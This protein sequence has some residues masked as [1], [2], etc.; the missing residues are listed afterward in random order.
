MILRLLSWLLSCRHQHLGLWFRRGGKDWQTC[1]DCGQPQ[2]AKVQAGP[3]QY[4]K[5]AVV[6]TREGRP[7]QPEEPEEPV[8][9]GLERR[10]LRDMG[11]GD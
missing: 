6:R 5:A 1:I 7:D 8:P 2:L 11:I 9:T 4:I 10:W 3:D